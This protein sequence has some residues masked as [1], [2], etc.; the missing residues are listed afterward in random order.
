MLT[1]EAYVYVSDNPLNV[2]DS[3]G[4]GPAGEPT[5]G[6]SN[7][8]SPYYKSHPQKCQ[9]WDPV[10]KL[11]KTCSAAVG[12][13]LGP[14]TIVTAAEVLGVA[15]IAVAAVG[16]AVAL[17]PVEAVVATAAVGVLLADLTYL[18]LREAGVVK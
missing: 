14:D 3:S 15:A 12:D 11:A 9:N 4:L 18:D 8:N 17:V 10:G 2:T 16:A 1:Q 13:I 5:N 7:A 6:C